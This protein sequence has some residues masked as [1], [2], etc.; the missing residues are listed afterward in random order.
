MKFWQVGKK[1]TSTYWCGNWIF[2]NMASRDPSVFLYCGLENQRHLFCLKLN[3]AWSPP[4][5]FLK[6][7][8][9][10]PRSSEGS[11]ERMEFFRQCLIESSRLWTGFPNRI[12]KSAGLACNDK[13]TATL[14][15]VHRGLKRSRSLWPHLLGDSTLPHRFRQP[16]F[17]KQVFIR[18]CLASSI[19]YSDV[20]GFVSSSGLIYAGAPWNIS[21]FFFFF[22]FA[23]GWLFKL[24]YPSKHGKENKDA[25]VYFADDILPAFFQYLVGSL[26]T[27]KCG[28]PQFLCLGE[29]AGKL[30]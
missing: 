3:K 29:S 14:T 17:W 1:N 16:G 21:F 28:M 20:T 25:P 11:R 22:V 23:I 19:R 27:P 5:P 30:Y 24:V 7:T 26:F 10:F 2:C 12:R 6:G 13:K 8:T 4:S 9:R 18:W 15:D